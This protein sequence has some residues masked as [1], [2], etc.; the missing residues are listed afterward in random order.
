[1]NVQG[2]WFYKIIWKYFFTWVIL[3]V[4]LFCLDKYY[5]MKHAIVHLIIYTTGYSLA[6]LIL[7]SVLKLE[8]FMIGKTELE[9]MNLLQKLKFRK[10]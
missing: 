3:S 2:S 1:M 10:G 5:P 7:S 8:G 9:N 6:Y 4:F